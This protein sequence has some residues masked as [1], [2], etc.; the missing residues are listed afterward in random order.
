ML[1]KLLEEKKSHHTRCRDEWT[2]I[3]CHPDP[4]LILK[5]SVQVQPHSE[6]FFKCKVQDQNKSKKFEKLFF[7]QQ[8]CNVSFPLTQSK[9]G[10]DLKFWSDLQRGSNPN[11]TKFAMV[12]IQTNSSPVQCSSLT[13]WP[14]TA[15]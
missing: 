1:R 8:K 5:N 9:S 4:V 14:M 7:S 13:C 2:V 6:N 11:S 12:R 15:H 3:L 10:P